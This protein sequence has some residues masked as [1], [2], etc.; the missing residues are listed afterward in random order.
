MNF[1]NLS[2]EEEILYSEMKNYDISQKIIK[3]LIDENIPKELELY[4]INDEFL[5]LWK[6]KSCFDEIK[7]NLPLKN[8]QIWRRI[9]KNSNAQNIAVGDINNM[10]LMKCEN[11]YMNE[12]TKFTINPK[13]NFHFITKECFDTFAKNNIIIND[14]V[15]KSKFISYKNK[16][17]SNFDDKIF[18]LY[19]YQKCINFLLYIL[20]NP[21]DIFY[22]KIK[23]ENMTNFFQQN[24]IDPNIE[25]FHLNNN[26]ILCINKSLANN[27]KKNKLFCD[28]ILFLINFEYNFEILLNSDNIEKRMLYLINEDWLE[29]FKRKLNYVFWLEKS[30]IENVN[31]TIKKMLNEYIRNSSNN[32][33]NMAQINPSNS[34]FGYLKENNTQQII[35]Y[36]SN[37]TLIDSNMWNNLKILFNWNIE[38]CVTAYITKNY[39]IIQFDENNLEIIEFSNKKIKSKLMFCLYK[40]FN[41]D[42]IINEIKN[43][44]IIGYYQKYNINNILNNNQTSQNLF[45]D[46]NLNQSIGKIINIKS[47]KNN[48]NN[49]IVLNNE[50]YNNYNLSLGLNNDFIP[51]NINNNIENFD[52]IIDNY[53]SKIRNYNIKNNN[54]FN[55]MNINFNNNDF[56]QDRDDNL[57]N[58]TMNKI[59]KDIPKLNAQFHIS[60]EFMN[61]VIQCLSSCKELKICLKNS[62]NFR[63]FNDNSKSFPITFSYAKIIN[64]DFPNG[65]INLYYYFLKELIAQ[66]EKNN[67]L[68]IKEPI[69]LYELL[70]NEIHKENKFK[71]EEF[72]N[73]NLQNQNDAREKIIENLYQKFFHPENNTKISQNFYGI[74]EITTKCEKCLQFNYEYDVFKFLEFDPKEIFNAMFS[75]IQNLLN[76]ERNKSFLNIINNIHKKTINLEQCLE[77]YFK[78]DKKINVFFCNKCKSQSNN[79]SY[80]NKL[81]LLPNI[82]CIVFKKDI[83]LKISVNFPEELNLKKYLENFVG[84]KNYKLIGIIIYS[85]ENNTY[86]S[87]TK[88]ITDN[89]WYLFSGNQVVQFNNFSNFNL[90]I[91]YMILYQHNN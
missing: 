65:N 86:V 89:Q 54:N 61:V 2:P 87:L 75:K 49:Y 84:N 5:N 69:T 32:N 74:R 38:I 70:L 53:I 11:N 58:F 24:E 17:I 21:N 25:E 90:G 60:N 47:A 9:R 16:L 36:Y 46:S 48:N 51:Q 34:I 4:I 8:P 52:N 81:I 14:F 29:E 31:P 30:Q 12:N 39:A 33:E 55:N 15:I 56:N 57:D 41:I 59:I 22:L 7:F 78:M 19:K 82:L 68:P 28:L 73:N 40:Y 37:F 62:S 91:P 79:S 71:K 88:N 72:P 45:S 83:N 42:E 13:S 77:Y 6:K 23:E 85:Y 66:I 63:F 50:E 18:V 44:G 3:K 35:K 1:I 27:A 76:A 43:L 10:I 80:N 64:V 67:N 26:S 20:E